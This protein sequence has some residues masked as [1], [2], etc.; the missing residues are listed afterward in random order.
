MK[1]L[2]VAT[3]G[4]GKVDICWAPRKE[5]KPKSTA[6]IPPMNLQEVLIFESDRNLQVSG[7]QKQNL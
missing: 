5:I 4:G 2:S 7:K 6:I 3:R 1:F